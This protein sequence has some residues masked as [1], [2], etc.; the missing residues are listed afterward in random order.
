MMSGFGDAEGEAE[1][2]DEGAYDNDGDAVDTSQ[3]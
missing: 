2:E 1:G 3:Q